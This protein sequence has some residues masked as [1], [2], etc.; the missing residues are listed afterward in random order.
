MSHC[1]ELAI[2]WIIGSVFCF[3]GWHDERRD[4]VELVMGIV[5]R[6]GKGELELDKFRLSARA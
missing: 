6:S 5:G 1:D 4:L 3:G 2:R